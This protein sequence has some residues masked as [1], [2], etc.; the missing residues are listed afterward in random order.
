MKGSDEYMNI[1][2]TLEEMRNSSK[3]QDWKAKGSL[4]ED[5]VFEICAQRHEKCLLYNS[6]MYPYQTNREGIVY[7]GNIKYENNQFVEYTDSST[8]DEIDIL[9]I[10]QFRVFV[11]EVK[12]YSANRIDVYDHWVNRGN[13]PLDKSP[14][15]QAEK[16]ARQLYHV[17]Y[18]VIPDGKTEYIKP[19][20][21]F[22]DRCTLRDDRSNHFRNYLPV[23]TLNDLN[24]TL[25]KNSKPLEYCISLKDVARKLKESAT[26]IKKTL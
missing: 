16:H 2:K 24:K 15:T 6:Y 12:S 18:D 4:G 19:I 5:A 10:T 1:N 23:C 21:C 11:I 9:Y 8:N 7:M 13:T 25:N 17:I 14:V 20:V 26:S 22:V 3:I